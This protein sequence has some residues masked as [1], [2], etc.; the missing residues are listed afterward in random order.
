MYAVCG[1]GLPS[2]GSGDVYIV[3]AVQVRGLRV[4]SAPIAT[5]CRQVSQR[6]LPNPEGVGRLVNGWWI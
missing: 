6:H 2:P 3:L 4:L 5:Y 1:L